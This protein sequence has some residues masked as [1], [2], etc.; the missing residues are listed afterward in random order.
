MSMAEGFYLARRSEGMGDMEA[1]LATRTRN[2]WP[3]RAGVR[4]P[5]FTAHEVLD[6][7]RGVTPRA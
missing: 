5:R 2:G 1:R 4:G 7:S 6:F 3:P